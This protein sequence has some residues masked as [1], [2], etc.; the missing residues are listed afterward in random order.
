M[1]YLLRNPREADILTDLALVSEQAVWS[2]W[3][4]GLSGGTQLEKLDV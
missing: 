4:L 2:T 3:P 1:F